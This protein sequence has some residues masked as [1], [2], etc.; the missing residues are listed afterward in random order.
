MKTRSVLIAAVLCVFATSAS[1][2]LETVI[3]PTAKE[4][5]TNWSY[6]FEPPAVDWYEAQFDASEWPVGPGGFGT[7]G[8]PGAVVGTFWGSSDVYI[9]KTFTIA[10]GTSLENLAWKIHHDEGVQIYLNGTMVYQAADYTSDYVI[11]AMSPDAA[12]ALKVG[13]NVMA[14]HCNQTDGGQYIDV[15]IVQQRPVTLVEIL[16]DSRINGQDWTYVLEEPGTSAWMNASYSASGWNQGKGG[17]GNVLPGMDQSVIPGTAWTGNDIWLRKTFTVPDRTF[18]DYVLSVFYDEDMEIFLN[19][20]LVISRTGY[21]T[22]FKSETL[23][24]EYNSLI[25]PGENLIAVHCRQSTGGQYIDVGISAVEAVPT[26]SRPM[27][28][29]AGNTRVQVLRGRTGSMGIRAKGIGQGAFYDFNGR[30]TPASR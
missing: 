3:L 18:T 15:G 10:E 17:F 13:E 4:S 2:Q 24:A 27:A 9:R 16:P 22:T 1:A 7:E 29:S 6:I 25:K 19:G 26:A 28:R 5:K 23:P 14:V 11:E 30:W 12:A 20:T 21:L 8:T